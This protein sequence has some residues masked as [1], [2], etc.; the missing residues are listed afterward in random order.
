VA[1]AEAGRNLAVTI[2]I[3]KYGAENLTHNKPLDK[4][5]KARMTVN[6]LLDI[7]TLDG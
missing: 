1:K 7:R 4:Q 6:S 2:S 5:T 3:W